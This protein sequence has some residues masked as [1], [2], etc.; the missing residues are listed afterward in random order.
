MAP[1]C[2]S[3]NWTLPKAGEPDAQLLDHGSELSAHIISET[4]CEIMRS[5]MISQVRS[6]PLPA[7]CHSTPRLHLDPL[8][9]HFG[10][11]MGEMT[12]M[13]C[14]LR[15]CFASPP[16]TPKYKV[17]LG[18]SHPAQLHRWRNRGTGAVGCVVLELPLIENLFGIIFLNLSGKRKQKTPCL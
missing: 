14:L 16:Q 7:L 13:D 18:F 6:C 5:E 11:R 3:Q 10:D 15:Y 17:I 4:P 2:P 8:Q 12:S 1:G 9:V